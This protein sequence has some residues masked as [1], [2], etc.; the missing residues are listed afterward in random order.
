MT[1]K[2]DWA[3][4]PGWD[5]MYEI[6]TDGVVISYHRK[7]DGYKMKRRLNI[8]GYWTC[9]LTLKNLRA[10]VHI[11]RLMALAF[12]PNPDRLPEILFLDGNRLNLKLSN[13]RW[14][15]HEES[16]RTSQGFT[17]EVYHN[18][19]QDDKRIFISAVEVAN[20]TGLSKITIANHVK[21]RNGKFHR[22]GYCIY[23]PQVRN[24]REAA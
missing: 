15:T 2:I 20:F 7:S 11:G 8:R 18:T 19:S 12:L 14:C 1:D 3:V 22:S 10:E 13:I 21:Y 17:Y 6:S 5:G 4:I 24:K 16:I 9:S 23:S